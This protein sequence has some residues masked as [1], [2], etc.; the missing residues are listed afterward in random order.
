MGSGQH[1]QSP[2]RRR[3]I[4]DATL[5]CIVE[6]GYHA[7]TIEDVRERSG[8]STGSIYHHFS[9]KE[10]LVA[11]LYADGIRRF[12]EALLEPTRRIDDPAACILALVTAT[13]GWV[14]DNLDLAR[15]L[16]NH[17]PP[18]VARESEEEIQEM[19]RAFVSALSDRFQTWLDRNAIRPIQ[20]ELLFPI[21]I[22][23]TY[24]FARRW[25]L[26]RTSVSLDDAA[27]DL[28]VAAWRSVR[29]LAPTGLV[30]AAPGSHN[31]S[32]VEE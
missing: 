11:A 2:H 30:R 26:G 9:S 22:G 1:Q 6:R 20:V 31:S 16:L 10:R 15:F 14:S 12:Q 24:E 18:A 3:L 29:P 19:N 32:V 5:A 17:P 8:A 23:P 13:L 28:A 27:G 21:L 4:L 7:T 25:L